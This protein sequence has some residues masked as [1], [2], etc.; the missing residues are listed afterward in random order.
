MTSHTG[1]AGGAGQCPT[2]GTRVVIAG[3]G[4]AGLFA[5]L[6]ITAL[7]P[8]AYVTLVTKAGLESGNTVAAQG[9]IAAA[10]LPGDSPASHVADTLVAGA[11]L[12][13]EAAVQVLCT[14]GPDRIADLITA[15]VRFDTN[16]EGSALHGGL[17]AAHSF[18][19]ILHA[20]K[21]ATGAGIAA[22]LAARA[23]D[24]PRITVLE[25]TFLTGIATTAQAGE[26]Q[27][28]ETQPGATRATGVQVLLPDGTSQT[29][30]ADAVVL[31]TG[32]LG[33]VYAHTSNPQQ[34]TGDGLACAIRAGAQVQDLEFIQF[35]PTTL[36]P[37]NFLISEAVRGEGAIL[38]DDHGKR[39]MTAVHPAAELAPRDVVARA[40]AAQM[41]AQ[42]GTPVYLD[43]T[44][45]HAQLPQGLAG[46]FPSIHAAV[47][48]A[49]F[50][51]R[52]EP[53]PVTPAAH[54]AMGGVRTDLW[55][56]TNIAGLFAAGEVARTGVH[57]A[58]RLASNS[59]LEGAVFA[60]RVA[61]AI[62]GAHG[63][64][65]EDAGPWPIDQGAAHPAT[66]RTGST[67]RAIDAH[68]IPEVPFSRS[69]LQ[70]VMWH[71]AG[72]VR[73]Y[74]GLSAALA[75]L[76]RWAATAPPATTQAEHEDANLLLIAQ[77]IVSAA[78]ARTQSA[79]AHF[80]ADTPT[81]EL[82]TA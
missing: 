57:G 35:H 82:V 77:G 63:P 20:G 51:W 62:V 32:G 67:A 8:G 41:A 2:A 18:P 59:L 3:S 60:D 28:G 43:A 30:T 48:A 74:A 72:L 6:R 25:H 5:A 26:T 33:Q 37:S 13:D 21:D 15:G 10:A 16:P 69:A 78:L 53:I 19:R 54:Y 65:T 44:A 31:A 47:L 75:T 81:R 55:G 61:R 58:N 73:T 66:A 17:E 79:G 42:G 70:Q 46:R 80:R 40:V 23:V 11:G 64:S 7:D 71:E 1:S 38:V 68:E 4:I 49:G 45:I 14:E 34:A 24:N 36:A 29:I 39:F 76:E 27:T 12:C 50:D 56:R 52:T 9:G 22:A